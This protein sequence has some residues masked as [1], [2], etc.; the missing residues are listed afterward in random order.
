MVSALAAVGFG[1][2]LTSDPIFGMPA[3]RT[4]V[5]LILNA[6]MALE[7]R[8]ARQ[9][10]RLQAFRA[11]RSKGNVRNLRQ[12]FFRWHTQPRCYRRELGCRQ[13][14]CRSV[15]NCSPRPLASNPSTAAS[16]AS[17]RPIPSCREGLRL[18][19]VLLRRLRG[20]GLAVH[21]LGLRKRFGSK[22]FKLCGGRKSSFAGFK[23]HRE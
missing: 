4:P 9:L 17:E 16:G 23:R 11:G 7:L 2:V 19:G 13:R 15:Q 21:I 1:G 22:L 8:C 20:S 3:F 14:E 5:S 18:L 6:G 12:R 10:H